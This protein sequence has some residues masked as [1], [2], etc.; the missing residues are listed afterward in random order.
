M[1]ATLIDIEKSSGRYKRKSGLIDDGH[2]QLFSNDTT[3][4]PPSLRTSVQNT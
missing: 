2:G 1:I 3:L 4:R